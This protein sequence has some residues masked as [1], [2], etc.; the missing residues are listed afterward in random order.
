MQ[1]ESP[2]AASSQGKVSHAGPL[3]GKRQLRALSSLRKKGILVRPHIQS[4]K[5]Q[6][7]KYQQTEKEQNHRE[8]FDQLRANKFVNL[9]ETYP[10]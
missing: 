9:D 4:K 1:D 6:T 10:F 2:T 8:C 3:E 7:E 5:I